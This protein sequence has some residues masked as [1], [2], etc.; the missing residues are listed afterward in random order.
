MRY[1]VFCLIFAAWITGM[2]A[3][4]TEKGAY[5]SAFSDYAVI[6]LEVLV[7]GL[8]LIYVKKKVS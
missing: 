1:I 5:P 6:F 7:T 8:A 3:L 4:L 2:S